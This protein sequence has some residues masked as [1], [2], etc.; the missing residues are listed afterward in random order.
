[1]SEIWDEILYMAQF[2]P[3]VAFSF[4]AS[5]GFTPLTR[6]LAIH[7][8]IVDQPSQRKIHRE[9]IPLLGGLAIFAAFML[10]VLIFTPDRYLVEFGAV[11]AGS[12][13][14]AIVGYI[15][16]RQGMNPRIKFAAQVIAGM[17]VMMAGIR[18]RL[19]D[20]HVLNYLVT[21]FWIIGITNAINL[22]D[23][24]D[25]LAAGFAAIAAG[26]FFILAAS[27]DLI[28]VASLSAALCGAALGFLRYNFNPASTFM[29]DTGSLVIG[30]IL[31]VLGIKLNFP[32][33]TH[34]VTWA[35]PILVLAIPIFDTTLV[36][37]TRLR[38]KRPVTQGGKD[39][40]SHRI[41]GLGFS[42]RRAVII[43]YTA[44]ALMGG[45]ALA[46]S[47]STAKVAAGI[48]ILVGLVALGAFIALERSYAKSHE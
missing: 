44:A 28:L 13:W 5:Y 22:M 39:H 29:G 16:D 38:E 27:Q 17:I 40:T 30:F 41:V 6:R 47:Q 20:Q 3:I 12:L 21:L 37:F 1:V 46:I 18:V 42:N 34:L 33:Q 45:A 10:A 19:F 7:W 48:I 32:A 9:P 36:T 2:M 8:N 35:I 31:A 11:L 4:L 25:G 15:D 26:T 43:L 14:L 24:M 23:N